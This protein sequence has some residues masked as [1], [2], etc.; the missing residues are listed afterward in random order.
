MSALFRAATRSVYRRYGSKQCR[1]S[2]T[3]ASATPPRHR[4]GR[5]TSTS[6]ALRDSSPAASSPPSPLSRLGCPLPSNLS[7]HCLPPLWSQ[8]AAPSAPVDQ[9]GRG[10]LPPGTAACLSR[11]GVDF[12][13]QGVDLSRQGV[14]F[15][16]QGVDFYRRVR[17]HVCHE[18]RAQVCRS[19][20]CRLVAAVILWGPG[21]WLSAE[22][23]S[24]PAPPTGR[25][26]AVCPVARFVPRPVSPPPSLYSDCIARASILNSADMAG[27]LLGG[28]IGGKA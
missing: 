20:H 9:A 22:Q 10:F 15:Y 11:Q 16:R 28:R 5:G 7:T 12:Y 21:L 3:C 2:H 25:L 27:S 13:R 17:R 23:R 18:R 1:N 14:D 8:W 24:Q 19:R 6:P 26:R 4:G